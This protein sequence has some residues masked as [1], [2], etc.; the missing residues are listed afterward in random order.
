M[1]ILIH[2]GNSI[3][4]QVGNL[5]LL[6]ALTDSNDTSFLGGT[7]D[8]Y[9]LGLFQFNIYVKSSNDTKTKLCISI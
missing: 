9:D 8:A 4:Q 7:P 6:V 2:I 1:L 5:A 3:I